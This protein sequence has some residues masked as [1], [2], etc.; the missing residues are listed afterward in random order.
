MANVKLSSFQMTDLRLVSGH[1][2]PITRT[3]DK[4]GYGGRDVRRL[5]GTLSIVV[6][7]RFLGVHNP[8]SCHG[9]WAVWA[10]CGTGSVVIARRV[11]SCTHVLINACQGAFAVFCPPPLLP[12]PFVTTTTP[13]WDPFCFQPTA[14]VC[15]FKAIVSST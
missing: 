8:S 15:P 5:R 7:I 12:A 13:Q 4:R 2:G 9:G 6:E 1:G 11:G 14:F 3:G 10:A